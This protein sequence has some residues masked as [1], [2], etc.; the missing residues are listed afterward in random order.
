MKLLKS[1]SGVAFA[2]M[3]S[4]AL[5]M[6][7]DIL[8]AAFIGGDTIMSAWIL[9]FT[10]PNLFRRLLGEGA[11]GTALVPLLTRQI[12]NKDGEKTAGKNFILLVCVLGGLLAVI[13]LI[14]SVISLLIAPFITVER[15]KLTFLILPILMPYSIFICLS[16]I[17]GAAL[18]TFKKFFLPALTSLILNII[19]IFS[20]F[21]LVPLFNSPVS[22]LISLS[23]SVLIAGLIQ[24][25][26][27]L[28]LLRKEGMLPSLRIS[29][30]KQAK[31]DPFLKEIWTLTLPGLIG[32]SALQI[33]F[34]TDRWL[35]CYLGNYAVPALYYSDRIVFLTIGIFAVA[36]GSVMLPDMSRFAA[37][38]DTNRMVKTMLIGLRQILFI[39]IPAAFFTFFFR[40]QIIKVLFM[41]GAFDAKALTETSWALGFYALGIPFFATIK[42]LVSGFY[43]RKEMK[44]PVKVSIYCIILNL[45][46]NLILMWPLRQG[47]IALA[48]V[49][50]SIINNAVLFFL[51]KRDLTNIKIKQI[52]IPALK[53][54][55]AS[56]LAITAA[57]LANNQLTPIVDNIVATIIAAI[58]FGLCYFIAAIAC[59]SKEIHEWLNILLT[60][61]N[62]KKGGN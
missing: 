11:L 40:E 48:T 62:F 1:T 25:G 20:L 16:G 41:R 24:L 59:E 35:A 18:N 15:I 45:I 49:I 36:M 58:V 37:N 29:Q 32:A 44:T 14:T 4:R 57:W 6:L 51:L 56:V 50:S 55:V 30:I 3:V 10:I 61:Q 54:V 31:N 5:G 39:C 9:A 22:I 34:L 33:S 38:N 23:I 19:L 47:G 12:S 8:F 60:S 21:C 46:L 42:I 17:A 27:M 28:L 53:T 13:T 43:S 52:S 7:R 2:T 26:I